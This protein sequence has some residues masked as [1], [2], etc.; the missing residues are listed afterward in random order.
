VGI[1]ALDGS[2]DLG[3]G[4]WVSTTT[5]MTA[6][7]VVSAQA[8]GV[9]VVVGMP[10]GP[11]VAIDGV[12]TFAVPPLDVAFV[13]VNPV[14]YAPYEYMP[15]LLQFG[16]PVLP[17]QT[18]FTLS[19]AL[20]AHPASF[21]TG[22][23]REASWAEAGY[24]EDVFTTVPTYGGSSGSAIIRASDYAIVAMTQY[25][26]VASGDFTDTYSGGVSA[27]LLHAAAGWASGAR[28]ITPRAGQPVLTTTAAV[29]AITLPSLRG[30]LA[31]GQYVPTS[32]SFS[33]AAPMITLATNSDTSYLGVPSSGA[34]VYDAALEVV[35]YFDG[36]GDIGF[37]AGQQV[38]YTNASPTITDVNVS[39]GY[40]RATPDPGMFVDIS[41][42]GALLNANAAFNS[43]T[44]YIDLSAVTVVDP[45][46]PG[47]FRVSALALT[48]STVIP[49]VA[50]DI[51]VSALGVIGFGT[52]DFALNPATD[53]IPSNIAALVAAPETN[54][55]QLYVAPFASADFMSASDDYSPTSSPLK[56]YHQA[57]T[58]GTVTSHVIQW[59]GTAQSTG[60][61]VSFQVVLQTDT[62]SATTSTASGL[63]TFLYD[64]TS[65]AWAGA[66]WLTAHRLTSIGL[67]TAL[68]TQLIRVDAQPQAYEVLFWGLASGFYNAY[69]PET[70]A[71]A[72]ANITHANYH[73]AVCNRALPDGSIGDVVLATV[74]AYVVD[75]GVPAFTYALGA[76]LPSSGALVARTVTSVNNLLVASADVND[77]S[78]V[79]VLTLIDA[80]AT[81]ARPSALV[82]LKLAQIVAAPA[83]AA[84]LPHAQAFV[85]STRPYLNDTCVVTGTNTQAL[86][87]TWTP[88]AAT[89]S[90][91]IALAPYV[92][93]YSPAGS[94][95]NGYQP[96]ITS[97]LGLVSFSAFGTGSMFILQLA[98]C[99]STSL[100][101][102]FDAADASASCVVIYN[103]GTTYTLETR[104]GFGGSVLSTTALTAPGSFPWTVPVELL[105]STTDGAGVNV[106]VTGRPPRAGNDPATYDPAG[107]PYTLV[108]ATVQIAELTLAPVQIISTPDTTRQYAVTTQT[109]VQRPPFF[110]PLRGSATSASASAKGVRSLKAHMGY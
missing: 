15:A 91:A 82:Q 110:N 27:A 93:T 78:L 83:A 13:T 54:S 58:I 90:A 52:A 22:V 56:V 70:P 17:G 87:Y 25:G 59:T 37:G 7:H 73:R 63:V 33:V 4:F 68:G 100:K 92:A 96:V 62:V 23:V 105:N 41:G 12:V 49:F 69:M 45:I 103:D 67:N 98:R 24:I 16:T 10:N 30:S 46:T 53:L 2:H 85:S 66:P 8:E 77:V 42:T 55:L 57:T 89:Y 29:G 76:W 88:S 50:T 84:T 34:V 72:L 106:L 38:T 28:S 19:N 61:P 95:P 81:A 75:A 97:V 109:G 9:R 71:S 107:G 18:V 99:A 86:T 5:V 26:F 44:G 6:W 1:V 65:G 51:W 48:P 36:A 60:D 39:V 74:V 31:L 14:H 32:G 11:P 40:V 101:T 94:S 79:R 102:Q 3:S 21:A 43:T 108:A 64:V 20:G 80:A 104:A 35:A 47:E